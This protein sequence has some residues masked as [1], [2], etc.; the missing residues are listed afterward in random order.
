M[1]YQIVGVSQFNEV[2]LKNRFFAKKGLNFIDLNTNL[3]SEKNNQKSEKNKEK[4]FL[5]VQFKNDWTVFFQQS[6]YDIDGLNKSTLDSLVADLKV[7]KFKKISILG[8]SDGVGDESLNKI[9]GEYRSKIVTNYLIN[10]GID[11]NL[12]EIENQEQIL[13]PSLDKNAKELS[14]YRKV[15]IHVTP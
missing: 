7:F 13:N 4:P 2:L 10:S 3:N 6:K 5:K 12:I 9:L 15:D 11:Q 1:E 14:K 8:F